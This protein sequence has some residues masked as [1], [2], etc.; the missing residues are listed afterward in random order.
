MP[1]PHKSPKNYFKNQE[2]VDKC[3]ARFISECKLSRMLGGRGWTYDLVQ[4]F[5]GKPF[6]ITPCGAVPKNDDPLVRIIHDYSFPSATQ[7]S[8]NSALINTSVQYISFVERAKQLSKV[9]WYIKVDLKNGYRQLGVHP[10]E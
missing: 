8:V 3:R 4:Q 7:G 10:S 6:Y 2:G 5:L 9:E 1:T